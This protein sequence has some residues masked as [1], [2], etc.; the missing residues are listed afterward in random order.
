MVDETTAAAPA[1]DSRRIAELAGGAAT[2]VRSREAVFRIEGLSVR[3]G[4]AL[5][6]DGATLDVHKNAVTAC[7]G[8]S[9]CG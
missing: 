3:Y 7:I 8:P 5:A 1:V 9:G 6:L 4:T 2:D